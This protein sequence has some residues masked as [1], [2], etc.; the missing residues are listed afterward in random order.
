MPEPLSQFDQLKGLLE[1]GRALFI[2][3]AGQRLNTIN[4]F[5]VAFAIFTTAYVS[6]FTREINSQTLTITLQTILGFLALGV[7]LFFR[8]LDKR[9]EVLVHHD[10]EAQN[11]IEHLILDRYGLNK[12]KLVEAWHA[13]RTAT[14][15]SAIMP[16]LYTFFG[17]ISL[18]AAIFPIIAACARH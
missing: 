2:Y 7:T 16:R 14:H 4:Y 15:Y 12:F 13:D 17:A 6:T 18:L 9:N 8:A 11:E 5:F 3:H 1:H 10:E